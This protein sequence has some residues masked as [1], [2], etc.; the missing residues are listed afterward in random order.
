MTERPTYDLFISYADT[1]RAW[2][3]GYLLDA[4]VQAG[5]RCHSEAAFALGMPRLLEFERAVQASQRTLLVLSSAYLADGFSQFTDLLAQTYGLE[6]ATWPVI[7]LIRQPVR[8]PPRLGM[9]VAL[10]A[11][12]PAAW[13]PVLAPAAP[14]QQPFQILP[15]RPHQ[16][17]DIHLLQQPQTEP[18]HAMPRFAFPK[19]WLHPHLALA[20]RIRP[21]RWSISSLRRCTCPG[22]HCGICPVDRKCAADP[23]NLAALRTANAPAQAAW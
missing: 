11:T 13:P 20:Q 4:L 17:L 8:L 7:P 22:T 14:A 21:R 18:L 2:V 1:D 19:Q 12:D 16:R 15:R 9:L 6:T 5:V 3:E 10:D 23:E